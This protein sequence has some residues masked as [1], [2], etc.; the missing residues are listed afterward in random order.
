MDNDRK[1]FRLS[2]IRRSLAM[3]AQKLPPGE[4]PEIYAFP[5]DPGKSQ[6]MWLMK[7]DEFASETE[8][9]AREFVET[10]RWPRTT[11]V[12]RY[13]LHLRLRN[14]VDY[15]DRLP[16]PETGAPTCICTDPNIPVAELTRV[17]EWLLFDLWS[18]EPRESLADKYG[19]CRADRW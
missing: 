18:A 10:W 9:I 14:A 1:H 4:G 5:Y 17:I 16:R 2:E 6:Q 12:I 7:L 3:F 8:S 11:K 19:E 15:L 13:Y